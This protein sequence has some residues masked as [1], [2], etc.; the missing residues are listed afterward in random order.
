M[1]IWEFNPEGMGT[2]WLP[3]LLYYLPPPAAYVMGTGSPFNGG[4]A[5]L[6]RDADHSPP[7]SAKVK[8]EELLFLS[9]LSLVWR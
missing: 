4:K 2:L 1:D 5:R 6:G 9:P 8:N 7:P 3:G